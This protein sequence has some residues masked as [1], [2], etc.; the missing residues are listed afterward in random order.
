[1]KDKIPFYEIVN[2]FFTGAVFSI[3]LICLLYNNINI[4]DKSKAIIE[5]CEKWSIVVGAGVLVL[6]Y[7]VGFLLNKIS[8]VTLGYILPGLKI[9]PR[10]EYSIDVS[11]IEM[12]NANFRSMNVELHVVRTHIVMYLILG[13]VA[14]VVKKWIVAIAFF[15]LIVVFVFS[16][17]RT[18][19]FMNKIK[20]GYK[21]I[22]N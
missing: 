22:S 5:Y 9:W 1:M 17:R 3:V 12:E 11:K 13:V 10:V 18:N 20:D 19:N 8:A 6:M 16:G 21:K 14:A 7:E 4:S 2:M 15:A